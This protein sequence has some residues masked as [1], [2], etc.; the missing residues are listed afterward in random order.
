MSEPM[1]PATYMGPTVI[2]SS[3]RPVLI[4]G[5]HVLVTNIS[6]GGA[7]SA[8]VVYDPADERSLGCELGTTARINGVP[9]SQLQVRS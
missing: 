1:Y 6:G 5:Q 2:G 3:R 4:E 8:T 7:G 9:L